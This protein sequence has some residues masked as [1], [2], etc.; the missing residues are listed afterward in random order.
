MVSKASCT[1]ETIDHIQQLFY[2]QQLVT[3]AQSCK[4]SSSTALFFLFLFFSTKNPIKV[5][6]N[7]HFQENYLMEGGISKSYIKLSGYQ[8]ANNIHTICL[9]TAPQ[10]QFGFSSLSSI[11]LQSSSPTLSFHSPSTFQQLFLCT[12]LTNF[13][14]SQKVN[15]SLLQVWSAHTASYLP[16]LLNHA[17]S[18]SATCCPVHPN[19]FTQSSNS[20]LIN[21][22]AGRNYQRYLSGCCCDMHVALISL[23]F[24]TLCFVVCLF[25]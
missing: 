17:T 25:V 20:D 8:K 10:K 24:A 15:F 22:C 23:I 14:L 21:W 1:R 5:T 9:E 12:L 4:I 3:C 11:S 7:L 16:P 18:S 19:L 6:E 2:K 13:G